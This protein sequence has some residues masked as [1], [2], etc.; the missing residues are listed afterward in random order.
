MLPRWEAPSE[1]ALADH[2]DKLGGMCQTIPTYYLHGLDEIPA[3]VI[4]QR[5]GV[6]V[7]ERG[8]GRTLVDVKRE[9]DTRKQAGVQSGG[10]NLVR[11]E[12]APETMT[13]IPYYLSCP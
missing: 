3:D 7:A 6:R 10:P 5:D 1:E 11:R 8:T 12:L 4:I 13:T 2:D 9:S